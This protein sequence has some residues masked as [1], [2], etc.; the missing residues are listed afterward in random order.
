MKLNF[1][2]GGHYATEV[3]GVKEL[4]LKLKEKFDVEIKFIPIEVPH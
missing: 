4:A 1:V 2:S 3:F